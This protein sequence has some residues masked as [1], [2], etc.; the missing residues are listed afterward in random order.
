MNYVQSVGFTCVYI[1][2]QQL[3]RNLFIDTKKITTDASTIKLI[4]HACNNC[5]KTLLPCE[6]RVRTK[7]RHRASPANGRFRARSRISKPDRPKI[8]AY[9]SGATRYTRRFSSSLFNTVIY[10]YNATRTSRKMF[11]RVTFTSRS[12]SRA[13]KRAL[14]SRDAIISDRGCTRPRVVVVVVARE[15]GAWVRKAREG[16]EFLAKACRVLLVYTAFLRARVCPSSRNLCASE[17][18][19]SL[20][21]FFFPSFFPTHSSTTNSTMFDVCVGDFDKRILV[22]QSAIPG[23]NVR[24]RNVGSEIRGMFRIF[25]FSFEL[26]FGVES[27]GAV[28]DFH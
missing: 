9:N 20:F 21:L 7:R 22:A 4:D 28:D 2:Y 13:N 6:S 17:K 19:I 15:C 24:G 18:K 25:F 10:A 12:L 11:K 27:V 16:L 26:E 14:H 3:E 1:T 8:L 23:E 5:N